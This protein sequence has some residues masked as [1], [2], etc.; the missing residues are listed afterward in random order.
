MLAAPV[1]CKADQFQCRSTLTC[2][3]RRW[4][5]DGESDCPDESDEDK[6]SNCTYINYDVPCLY[7]VCSRCRVV[8]RRVVVIVLYVALSR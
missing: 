5:C 2:I 7:E 4:E 8:D 1:L 3:P 6:T